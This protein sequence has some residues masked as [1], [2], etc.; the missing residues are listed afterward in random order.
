MSNSK[1]LKEFGIKV[2]HREISLTIN[3]YNRDDKSR[4]EIEFTP[5]TKEALIRMRDI[6]NVAIKSA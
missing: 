4:A 2:E 3:S 6:L 1:I 5:V